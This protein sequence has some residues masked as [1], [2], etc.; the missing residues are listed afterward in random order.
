MSQY[1]PERPSPK[2]YITLKIGHSPTLPIDGHAPGS[3]GSGKAPREPHPAAARARQ[4][5][6]DQS[7]LGSHR[8]AGTGGGTPGEGVGGV[9]GQLCGGGN[10]RNATRAKRRPRCRTKGR[11]RP[12]ESRPLPASESVRCGG[13]SSTPLVPSMNA[14]LGDCSCTT[15]CSKAAPGPG[16]S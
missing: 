9:S 10:P 11:G 15:P 1:E 7:L 12:R 4:P 14:P 13:Q 2:V 16:R 5:E 6:R 3:T 8:P